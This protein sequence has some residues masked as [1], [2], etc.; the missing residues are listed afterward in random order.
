LKFNEAQFGSPNAFFTPL[1]TKRNENPKA[2]NDII[3][4]CFAIVNAKLGIS[5]FQGLGKF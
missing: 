5:N 4:A 2:M 3:L 1:I